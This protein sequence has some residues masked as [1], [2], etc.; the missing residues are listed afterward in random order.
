MFMMVYEMTKDQTEAWSFG[1]TWSLTI[2]PL[3]YKLTVNTQVPVFTSI[4]LFLFLSVIHVVQGCKCCGSLVRTGIEDLMTTSIPLV[5]PS[6][7]E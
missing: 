3:W 7:V 5:F 1:P 6:E 4:S 2:E